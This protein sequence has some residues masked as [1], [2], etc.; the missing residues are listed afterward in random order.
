MRPVFLILVLEWVTQA[1]VAFMLAL[2]V[3]RRVFPGLG[4]SVDWKNEVLIALAFSGTLVLGLTLV[5]LLLRDLL[6]GVR[7]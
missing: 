3:V 2:L 1:L 7:R 5:R 4:L 6:R